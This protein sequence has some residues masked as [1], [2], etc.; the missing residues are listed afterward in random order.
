MN[1]CIYGAS[2]NEI[3]PLYLEAGEQLGKL[4]A[5]HDMT[6]VFGGGDT[7]MMGAVLRGVQQAGGKSIGVSPRFFDVPGILA[8][9]CT[10]FYFTDTMRQRKQMM[11]DFADAFIMTPGSIGTYEEFF[12][13]LTLRQLKQT[14]KPL[15][16]L[17]V[18]GFFEPLIGMLQNAV[19]Q[20]FCGSYIMDLFQVF[21]TPEQAV[22]WIGQ[23]IGNTDSQSL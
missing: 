9:S 3:A 14:T 2:S 18:N 20:K 7:G 13:I 12:E 17:N 1:V 21:D 15:G 8:Q 5:E 16:I 19:G 4:M 6:L 23:S 22:D 10:E 11:D